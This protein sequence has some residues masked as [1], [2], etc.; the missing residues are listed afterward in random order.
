MGGVGA[1]AALGSGKTVAD[2]GVSGDEMWAF[3]GVEGERSVGLVLVDLRARFGTLGE[4][5]RGL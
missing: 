3:V 4:M 2:V 1:G 5:L